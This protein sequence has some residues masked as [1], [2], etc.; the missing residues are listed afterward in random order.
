MLMTHFMRCVVFLIL[1]SSASVL[2][3]LTED[4]AN[5]TK[6]VYPYLDPHRAVVI[7]AQFN[8]TTDVELLEVLV[9]NTRARTAIGA[10]PQLLLELLNHN[11]QVI[12]TRNAWYPLWESHWDEADEAESLIEADS[13]EGTFY[14]P[15]S[16]S[17]RKVRITDI[18]LGQEL[19]TVDVSQPV[20]SYCQSNPTT[21]ICVLFMDDF[22]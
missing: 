1:L 8:S 6:P 16:E 21:P 15:L 10:P 20:V 12:A 18:Q 13:G 22:E 14:L 3:Q 5:I 7:R 2:A 4:P 11:D 19:I 17:L 9:A